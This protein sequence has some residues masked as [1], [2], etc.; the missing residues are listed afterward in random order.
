MP[1]LIWDF[2]GRTVTLLVLSCRGSYIERKMQRN[3]KFDI[4]YQN[5][6]WIT[7]HN[8]VTTRKSNQSL[9]MIWLITSLSSKR[10]QKTGGHNAVSH[11]KSIENPLSRSASFKNTLKIALARDMS[12]L[13][14]KGIE[15]PVEISTF[16][17]NIRHVSDTVLICWRASFLLKLKIKK[18]NVLSLIIYR[19]MW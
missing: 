3:T 14:L 16:D 6:N 19:Q 11:T 17:V 15:I 8:F 10:H 12:S 2:A 18:E 5:N 4:E 13:L 1:R 7:F 9:I